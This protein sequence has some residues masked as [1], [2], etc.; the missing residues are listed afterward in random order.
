MTVAA[1]FL[2]EG[3]AGDPDP[4]PTP[5]RRREVIHRPENSTGLRRCFGG[6]SLGNL[7]FGLVRSVLVRFACDC[8]PGARPGC[9]T[10]HLVP[11]I[12]RGHRASWELGLGRHFGSVSA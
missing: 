2:H 8:L 1:A 12:I 9:A 7:T 5:A 4:G 10:D 6:E 11:P 3:S